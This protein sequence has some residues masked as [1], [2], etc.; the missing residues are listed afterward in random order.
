MRARIIDPQVKLYSSPEANAISLATL[1][2][3]TEVEF[4]KTIKKEGKKWTEVLMPSGQKGYIPAETRVFPF[5]LGALLQNN[6]SM[7]TSPSADSL[8]RATLGRN[9]K[10]YMTDV[11]RTENG[12]WVKV[13]DLSGNEGYISGRTPLRAIA[14]KTKAL[15]R[16]NMISGALWCI[17]GIVV[18][19]ITY[20]SA[21]GGGTYVVAW[22]AILFGFI[23]LIQG[24]Y[25]FFTAKS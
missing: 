14:E 10:V 21:S 5:R 18:T 4:G 8:V 17:G 2:A 24:I 6:V 12:D 23:Q 22:G 3:G 16:K 15:A 11:V 19:V 9:T 1:V 20:N 7:Y 25:Q 13:R